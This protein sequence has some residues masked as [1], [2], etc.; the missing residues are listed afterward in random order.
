[1]H[2]INTKGVSIM[3]KKYRLVIAII[4]VSFIGVSFYNT[5]AASAS[6]V[7]NPQDT[8]ENNHTNDYDRYDD[9]WRQVFNYFYSKWNRGWED[10]YD[11]VEQTPENGD[12][13]EKQSE[14]DY[15]QQ[16]NQ[17]DEAPSEPNQEV[18]VQKP[19]SNNSTGSYDAL[20]EVSEFEWE[21]IRLTNIER[22]KY[23][24]NPLQIDYE[25]N[26]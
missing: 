12:D 14:D 24:L 8:E 11:Y 21:V 5:F 9:N 20:G 6:T 15:S 26:R 23:G 1:M 2:K 18:D 4:A 22:E 10:Q 19:Q 25:L 16:N 3:F 13:S 17:Q 7:F